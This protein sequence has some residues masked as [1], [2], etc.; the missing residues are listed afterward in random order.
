M[1]IGH[2][3]L[4]SLAQKKI[5]KLVTGVDTATGDVDEDWPTTYRDC[6]FTNRSRRR[7]S[8]ENYRTRASK[9]SGCQSWGSQLQWSALRTQ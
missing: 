9:D 5:N 2:S 1:I 8:K 4:N 7:N 6:E 3:N